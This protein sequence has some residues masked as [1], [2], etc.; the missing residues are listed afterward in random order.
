MNEVGVKKGYGRGGAAG[1]ACLYATRSFWHHHAVSAPVIRNSLS[2]A[3]VSK[4]QCCRCLF[5]IR[6]RREGDPYSHW[7]GF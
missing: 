5:L 3:G 7:V 6:T 4:R 1:G 2:A